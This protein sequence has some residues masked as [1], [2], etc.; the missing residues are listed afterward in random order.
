MFPELLDATRG[1]STAARLCVLVMV[2]LSCF[3]L[4]INDSWKASPDS[5]L[6]LELGESLAHGNG[7]KFNGEHHTYVP[8]GYPVFI[9][10]I[11]RLFGSD[12]LSY[13]VA[14]AVLGIVTGFMGYFLMLKLLGPDPAF[15]LG[16]LFA[17]NNTLLVN[18]TFE[19][20]D[21]LFALVGFISLIA[22]IYLSGKKN[23]KY[24]LSLGALLTGVTALV[25]ING[26]GLS[27]SSG[28]FL[29]LSRKDRPFLARIAASL[30]FVVVS[31]ILPCI[32][33][34]HKSSYAPS[35]N[36]GEYIRAVA[37]RSLA[38]QLSIIGTAAMDY[39][40]EIATAIAGVSIKTGVLEFLIVGLMLIGFYVS[41][42]RGERLLTCLT[43]VQFGG[44]LLS[45][46]GSRYIIL[47]IPGLLLFLFMGVSVCLQM[48]HSKVTMK[49]QETFT[50]RRVIISIFL[51]LC[52]TNLGQSVVTISEARMAL[53]KGGAESQRDKPFFVAARWLKAH[54]NGKSIM[55]MNP[56]IIR[57]LTGIST[58]ETL[59]SGAPEES[60]W[61]TTRN[62]IA[63]LIEKG[64]P[65][66][67]FVDN[68]DPVLKRLILEAAES[69]NLEFQI[70]PE[71]SFGN[72]YYL[73]RLVN[74]D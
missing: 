46:A 58:L 18:S 51:L 3:A 64:N 36:E 4:V 43:A 2:V 68:R 10:I 37:G 25:R 21:V 45:P 59:R 70:I 9:A 35:Y 19:T 12:F 28:L 72:R 41:L 24:L 61:P 60:V 52:L 40:S 22:V 49:W 6:Y 26:W 11:A 54:Q 56:R 16:G 32:W 38:T 69:R 29:F 23:E 30:I 34:F 53:E 8:P 57:Y 55:T 67:L 7:Y 71:A 44:L 31:L 27:L 20:S 1:V 73:G 39:A 74:R 17:L 66:F 48:I 33:E 62:Q 5:A 50:L 65:G 13:R 47:L 63:D 14:M 15:V 42:M